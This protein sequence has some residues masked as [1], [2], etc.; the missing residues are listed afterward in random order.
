MKRIIHEPLVH[1][2]LIGAALFA[3]YAALNPAA[4][5]RPGDI[6]VT[7]GRIEHLAAT[8]VRVWQRPPTAS[9]VKG[10]VDDYVKEEVMSREAVKLGLDRDDPLI[11]RRL[12]QKME[13]LA[14][15]SGAASEP[16]DAELAEYLAANPEDF[17][18]EQRF[19]FR[20]VFLDP[21]K[22]GDRLDADVAGLL[23]ELKPQGDQSETGALGDSLLLSNAFSSE[24]RSGVAAQFG[25][26]F[27][28]A[29]AKATPGEWGGP[30]TSGYGLHLVFVAQ[31]SEGRLPPLDEVRERVKRELVNAR[32]LAASRRFLNDLL[33]RYRVVIEWPRADAESMAS[34]GAMIR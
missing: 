12:R 27:A 14:E 3:S 9:E 31:R 7:A 32:R 25:P 18:Q 23:A 29:L 4:D 22:R 33:A 15:D 34:T 11:R 17:R 6:T 24:P 30:F 2:L 5:A 26:Q 19:T 8:F 13:F 20:Q 28:A 21:K 10:L 1:F 16:T